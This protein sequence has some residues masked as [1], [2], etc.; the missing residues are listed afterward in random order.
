MELTTELLK[1]ECEE[2]DTL[3]GCYTLEVKNVVQNVPAYHGS[4]ASPRPD[5]WGSSSAVP[6]RPVHPHNLSPSLAPA[7]SGFRSPP[8]AA[9]TLHIVLC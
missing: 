4:G 8:C 5:T 7:A 9:G 3:K 2:T 6:F 1:E